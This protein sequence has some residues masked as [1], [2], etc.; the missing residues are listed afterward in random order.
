MGGPINKL[1]EKT[2]GPDAE[3]Q[4]E[5]SLSQDEEKMASPQQENKA[6]EA[7]NAK[8]AMEEVD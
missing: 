6:D 7:P 1:K 4:K 8:R 3:D 2:Q 5:A